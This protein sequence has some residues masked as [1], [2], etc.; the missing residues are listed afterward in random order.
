[1]DPLSLS[2]NIG[3]V[4]GLLD[5][6]CRL[7][8][9]TYRVVSAIKHAPEEIKR[10]SMELEEIDFLL[11]NIHQY[12]QRYQRQHPI[13]VAESNSAIS[14]LFK[15]L[16]KLRLEYEVTTEIVERNTETPHSGRRQRLRS[17]GNRVKLVLAGEL[18]ATFKTLSRYKA[19][20]SINLQVL[21]GFNDLAV[22]DSIQELSHT[23]S[24]LNLGTE[25]KR[26]A[27]KEDQ[28]LLS[29]KGS[30]Q[31]HHQPPKYAHHE[32]STSLRPPSDWVLNEG[33]LDRATLPLMLLKPKIQEALSLLTLYK[34]GQAQL[35][36]QDTNWIQQ[37]L[38]SLLVLCHETAAITLKM[39]SG[40]VKSGA[41]HTMASKEHPKTVSQYKAEKARPVGKNNEI[42]TTKFLARESPAGN[43]SVRIQCIKNPDSGHTAVSDIMLL[44]TPNPAIHTNGFVISLA[45]LNQKLQQPPIHRSISMYTVV[46]PNSPI[47]ECVESNNIDHLRQ[48]LGSREVTPDIR[49]TD[50]ESLL[51]VAARH[52]RLEICEL[53]INEGA[54]PSHCCWDGTN[55]IYAVRNAFWYRAMAYNV[56]K[57]VLNQLL[58]LFVRAGCDINSVALGGNPLHFTVSNTL[59]GSAIIDE[60]EI[61]C[62]VNLLICLGCDIEHENSDG[63]TPLLYNAC[64]PGWNG[65]AVLKEL[66][67]WGANPHAKTHLGEGPL[68]LAIAYSIPGTVHGDLGFRCL[69]ARLGLLL[70]AGCDPNLQD[71]NGHTV[72]DFALSSPR[73]WFQW[74]LAMERN[75]SL[76][77]EEIIRKE[78]NSEGDHV[79]LSSHGRSYDD[80]HSND[81]LESDWESCS[82]SDRG[83]TDSSYN[84]PLTF[85]SDYNHPFLSWGG[86][87][88][89]SIPPSCWD[90]GL[91]VQLEDIAGKKWQALNIFQTLRS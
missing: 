44:L 20:L 16:Q 65:V 18:K 46:D 40:T 64:I 84:L 63:L 23:L 13:M 5:A 71:Q 2:A 37:E 45:R 34:P 33:S 49:N 52:L 59:P 48:L 1:M 21:A 42:T 29:E 41:S 8:K 70:K 43:V 36:N 76:P 12:C 87:F 58:R 19:Q 30:I 60:E 11:L 88:P 4:I 27:V 85:C 7:G 72:S 14:H 50:N 73:T 91:P 6:V 3:A 67:Q 51:S 39:Q 24:P 66:L 68:H 9:E 54:D 53:L 26:A 78:D 32:A 90:C 47:F 89:W 38:E 82:D 10:L 79:S 75:Q 61:S 17:M 69:Q 80:C 57:P 77:I 56:P 25:K 86:F 62:L 15:L 81:D 74:C 55:A 83:E 28:H 22:H 31:Y 35:S